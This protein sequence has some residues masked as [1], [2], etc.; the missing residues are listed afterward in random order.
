MMVMW[1]GFQGDGRDKGEGA[2]T[3]MIK[4][5]SRTRMWFPMLD[6]S[7]EFV[8]MKGDINDKLITGGL[9]VNKLTEIF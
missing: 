3:E 8:L 1:Y 2:A 4:L 9:F 6:V 7:F 5:Q